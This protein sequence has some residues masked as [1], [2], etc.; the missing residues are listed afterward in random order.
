MPL[1]L[2]R[3]LVKLFPI[4]FHRAQWRVHGAAMRVSLQGCAYQQVLQ[5]ARVLV[6]LVSRSDPLQ[7]LGPPNCPQRPDWFLT[8]GLAYILECCSLTQT[9]LLWLL[10]PWAITEYVGPSVVMAIAGMC[11]CVCV[12]V[13]LCVGKARGKRFWDKKKGTFD[14]T[15]NW[16]P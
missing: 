12:C 4:L 8:D 11:V 13:F 15:F 7:M 14:Q 2:G 6:G 5:E 10:F 3:S 1:M 9:M 16:K